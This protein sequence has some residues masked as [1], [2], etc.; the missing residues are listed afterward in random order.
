MVLAAA[1]PRP[2]ETNEPTIED[3]PE[4]T[5]EPTEISASFATPTFPLTLTTS[6]N[7]PITKIS[8]SLSELRPTTTRR[9]NSQWEQIP[10]LTK[11]CTCKPVT[12]D[13]PC[14]AT[15]ALQVSS[16]F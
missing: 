4:D 15:D 5:E 16:S 14:W 6:L 11:E 13:Y 8:K 10:V 7:I 9:K 2:Q 3:P 1:F 12:A